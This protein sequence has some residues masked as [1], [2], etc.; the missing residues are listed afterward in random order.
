MSEQNVFFFA[1]DQA[2][3]ADK[4]K[5]LLGGKGLGLAKMAAAGVAVPPGFTITAEVCHYFMENGNYPEGLGDR[6]DENVERLETG[7]EFTNRVV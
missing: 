5:D 4:T 2:E 1:E 6:V 3:G 7:A